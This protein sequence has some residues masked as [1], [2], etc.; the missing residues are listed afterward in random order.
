MN[1]ITT[2]EALPEQWAG[3]TKKDI[4]S[5]ADV[6]VSSIL[7]NGKP[8]EFAERISA[9]ESFLKAVKDDARFK[10]YVREELAKNGGKLTTVS[11]AKIEAMEGGTKY[12]FESCGDLVL[13]D[14]ELQAQ[15]LNAQI[16]ARKDML[17]A[18]PASGMEIR[19]E[20]EL[21]TLY[22]PY[23]TSVSTYKITLAK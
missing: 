19:H 20:D 11:G 22:P 10:E 18:L 16:A 4:E 1:V 15:T 21:I 2:F 6:Q 9:F 23:K 8:I 13:L 5:L 7:E 12:H 3:L 17:K 14:L